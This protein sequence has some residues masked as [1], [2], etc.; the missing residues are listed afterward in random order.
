MSEGV[1]QNLELKSAR[2]PRSMRFGAVLALVA[3]LAVLRGV[4][5]TGA[6]AGKAKGKGGG[7]KAGGKGGGKAGGK[8]G[9]TGSAGSAGGAAASPSASAS[10]G[11]S[12]RNSEALKKMPKAQLGWAGDAKA[13][14]EQQARLANQQVWTT[15][16]RAY[17]E[18]V[19]R[20]LIGNS[21]TTPERLNQFDGDAVC[22]WDCYQRMTMLEPLVADIF[23]TGVAGCACERAN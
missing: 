16:Q 12:M 2:R 7:G 17:L 10:K 9:G 14:L 21:T 19:K 5:S 8:G 1:A 13:M 4:Q 23:A 15:A 3:L 6:P 22:K 20:A 11:T 18:S